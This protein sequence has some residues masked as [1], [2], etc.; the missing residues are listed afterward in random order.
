MSTL[1]TL[2]GNLG[3]A[4][5]PFVSNFHGRTIIIPQYDQNFDRYINSVADH[6]RDKGVP[7]VFYMH[8]VIPTEQGY[9]SVGYQQS[10]PPASPA[11][12]DFDQY[13]VLRDSSE[14]KA[15]FVPAAGKNYI[16][17]QVAAAWASVNPLTPG[18]FPSNGLVTASYVHKRTFIYYEKL[19]AYE[20]DFTLGVF[21]PVVFTALNF[22]N[23]RGICSAV[24]YNIAFDD[25]TIF[26]SSITTE[27]DFTPSLVT[28]AG[29]EIP[30]DVKGKIVAV[31]PVPQGFFIYSTK[32]VVSAFYSGNVRFPWIFREVPNSAGI[33]SPEN[34]AWQATLSLQYAWTTTGLMKLDRSGAESVFSN[35]TDFVTQKVFEDWDEITEILT[36]TY[37]SSDYKTKISFV[38]SRY[39]VFSYGLSSLTHAL[40][41][42]TAIKRWGKLKIAHVDCF[43]WPAPNFFGTRTYDQ[44]LGTTYD[45]LIGNTYDQLSQQQ[46]VVS[47]PRADLCFLQQD[48]KVQSIVFDVGNAASAGVMFIGKYQFVRSNQITLLASETENVKQG[49]NFTHKWFTSYDGKTFQKTTVPSTSPNFTQLVRRF[50]ARVTGENH[51]LYYS[52][53]FNMVSFLIEF[54]IGGQR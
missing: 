15:L 16:Y 14:N 39:L 50:G 27:T 29:S 8:N 35:L 23:I 33:N 2:R 36:T 4:Q 22:A 41:Y 31:L 32:N 24:G 9:Q 37:A 18:S 49:A 54:L 17:T 13:F 43:E 34:V 26:W 28:G 40:I 30:N 46:F 42:D 53:G 51:T 6:D 7:Q 19:G 11:Q 25:T 38:G 3:S 21:A 52:G 48:G 12:T 10:I 1:R 47:T 20:Y 44:L 45:Q 5:F